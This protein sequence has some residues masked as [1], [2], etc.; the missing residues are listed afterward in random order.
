MR[1]KH[2]INNN[3]M[4]AYWEIEGDGE[5][6]NNIR[7]RLIMIWKGQSLMLEG[8]WDWI[9]FRN[10]AILQ[11]ERW[12]NDKWKEAWLQKMRENYDILTIYIFYHET[13]EEIT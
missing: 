6:L 7:V 13:R 1:K 5:K 4:V 11:S 8:E 12:E 9:L 10:E 2:A 3:A